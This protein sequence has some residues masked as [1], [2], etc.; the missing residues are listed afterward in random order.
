MREPERNGLRRS[1]LVSVAPS[2]AYKGTRPCP[3]HGC[4]LAAEKPGCHYN[5]P[6]LRVSL[7]GRLNLIL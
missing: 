6:T 1:T 7:G 3:Q 4:E 2:R 5:Q